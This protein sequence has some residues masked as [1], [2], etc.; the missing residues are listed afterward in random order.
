M[1][2][3]MPGYIPISDSISINGSSFH[4]LQQYTISS[5]IISHFEL[6]TFGQTRVSVD[7]FENKPFAWCLQREE[8][9]IQI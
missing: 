1:V 6:G 4:L 3:T 5:H 7:D 8:E 9:A 2:D